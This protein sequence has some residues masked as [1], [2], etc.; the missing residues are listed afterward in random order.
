[1]KKQ[2]LLAVAL[3]AAVLFVSTSAMAQEWKLQDNPIYTPWAEQV[4]PTNPWPEYPRPQ[5]ER[6]M[7]LSLNG[8]WDYAI[9]PAEQKF[10]GQ[11]DGRI[12]VPFPFESALSGVKKTVGKE[13]LL[14]YGRKFDVP[15]SWK[16]QR[17]LLNFEAVDWK[18]TVYVN[19]KEVGRHTGGYAPFSVDITDALKAEGDQ[20][21]QVVVFDPTDD[22][23][24]PIGKQIKNPHGIWYTSVTGIWQ[25]VWVEA[26]SPLGSVT[27]IK[28][29]A[30]TVVDGKYVPALDGTVSV[31]GT[32]DAQ[33]GLLCKVTALDDGTPLASFETTIKDGKF[34]GQLKIENPKL[35]TPDTPNLYDLRV[36]L[37]AGKEVVDDVKSYFGIRTSTLGKKADGILRMLLNDEFVFQYGPLDQGWWPDGLYTPP[38]EE[39]MKF[40]L[41]KTK[42]MGFN[43]L[44]KHVKAESRRF[45]Y[46]CDT[47][48]LMI[49]QDMPSGDRPHYIRPEDP[50]ANRSPEAKENYYHEWGEI[51]TTLA[52]SP[53]I[54]MWVPFN[55]GWG[56]FDTCK[57][58]AWTKAKDPT[59]L[60]DCASGWSDRPCGDVVDMHHYPDP[61][62]P[63]DNATRAIVLGEFG[64]LGLPC[65]GHAWKEEGNWGY[66][67]FKDQDGLYQRYSGLIRKLRPLIDEGLS[68]AVYTQTTDVEIEVNGLFS[69]DRKIDKM[70]TERVAKLNARLY[71]PTPKSVTLVETSEKQ[72]QEWSYTFD[73]PADNWMAEDFDASGWKKGPAGFGTE[74]TPGAIIG[75]KWDTS[76]IWLRRAFTLLNIIHDEDAEVY[77]NGKLIATC[78]GHV[79]SYLEYELSDDVKQLLKQGKNTIAIHVKQTA[80]GQSIDAGLSLLF[81]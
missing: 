33:D 80:G 24:Q 79:G 46:L 1:M 73:K 53:S 49:W 69:Y 62:R 43:M 5:L 61:K 14:Y 39:A 6:P 71:K 45:Y 28:A 4:D 68:A 55:E 50:D 56:Q 25:S 19:G 20:E 64:G 54:V 66:V 60:V 74:G 18:A 52:N 41:V 81:E 59:R 72:K 12:L 77:L 30:G 21:L 26:V 16:N 7:W 32:A 31:E 37:K 51:M 67:S 44:R 11:Y 75:T 65:K 23:Y 36:E 15:P 8:L 13:N 9:L 2:Y 63:A 40:D 17:V 34:A 76:D 29:Y 57:V 10:E 70:G 58:V 3:F 48:G 22:G 35:W 38:T 47:L 27:N 42:E 78:N